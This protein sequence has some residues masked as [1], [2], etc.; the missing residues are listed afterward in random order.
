MKKCFLFLFVNLIFISSFEIFAEQQQTESASHPNNWRTEIADKGFEFGLLNKFE[1]WYLPK[2]EQ[3]N[4]SVFFINNLHTELLFDF[5]KIFGYAGSSM[6]FDVLWVN[7][8]RPNDNIGSAQGISNLEE[9]NN[10]IIFQW[11]LEQNLFNDKLS[12]LFGLL[13]LN[14]EFDVKESKS[15]FLTPSHGIGTDFAQSG[16]NGPS[17]FPVTSLAFRALYNFTDK[18]SLR[19]GIFDGIPGDTANHRGTKVILKESDGLLSVAEWTY[20]FEQTDNDAFNKTA[21]LAAWCFT[22][23]TYN[24]LGTINQFGFYGIAQFP[25]LMTV[26]DDE[27]TGL[28]SAL[29]I[30]YADAKTHPTDI[31]FGLSLL[32]KGLLPGRLNDYIGLAIALSRV[33][34]DYIDEQKQLG[35]S[36]KNYDANI[37]LLYRYELTEFLSLQADVQYIINPMYSSNQDNWLVGGVR[38]TFDL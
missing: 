33:S 13:D 20:T 30:G 18:L 11:Y 12:L 5:D 27:I 21:K 29:R 24:L 32:Y 15:L 8:Q 3:D 9:Q 1:T 34:H 28:T 23:E 7:S 17:I 2:Q 25:L 14:G 37:E 35:N 38:I 6:L 22:K 4:K 19:Y 31:Y 16:E 10:I 26:K 36:V